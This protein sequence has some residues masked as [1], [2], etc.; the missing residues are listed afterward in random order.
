[1]NASRGSG[2]RD[3]GRRGAHGGGARRRASVRNHA[4]GKV[5]KRG[6]KASDAPYCNAEILGHLLDGR[7][8]RSGG[9]SGGR[10]TAVAGLRG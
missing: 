9:M 7:K 5:G 10:G 6:K 2:W 8:R 1:V 3:G 4:C